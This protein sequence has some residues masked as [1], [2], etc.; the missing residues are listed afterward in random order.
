[1]SS[2]LQRSDKT[3]PVSLRLRPEVKEA[4]ERA[5]NDDVRSL[6]SL[7]EKALVL[8]LRESGH[9]PKVPEPVEGR[10]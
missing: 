9:L 10:E 1:M 4:A 3:L 5:A 2:Q 7:I 8:Y 6:S